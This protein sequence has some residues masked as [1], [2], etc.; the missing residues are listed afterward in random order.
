LQTERYIRLHLLLTDGL[1]V[2]EQEHREL[3]R[4]YTLRATEQAVEFL[5]EHIMGTGRALL[6]ALRKHRAQASS[7]APPI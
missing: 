2:A 4:L 1:N 5:K 7:Q 6:L 3:L